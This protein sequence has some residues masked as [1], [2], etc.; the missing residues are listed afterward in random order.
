MTIIFHVDTTKRDTDDPYHSIE[1]EIRAESFACYADFWRSKHRSADHVR[2][3]LMIEP[4]ISYEMLVCYVRW[5]RHLEYDARIIEC[6]L[7]YSREG[8]VVTDWSG[9][10]RPRKYGIIGR[11]YFIELQWSKDDEAAYVFVGLNL[12]RFMTYE[13]AGQVNRY[14][15]KLSVDTLYDLFNMAL[16]D[17]V[18]MGVHYPINFNTYAPAAYKKLCE[19]KIPFSLMSLGFFDYT[20]S[21]HNWTNAVRARKMGD[22]N[23][24]MSSELD[25]E[26]FY[27]FVMSNADR[28]STYVTIDTSIKKEEIHVTTPN[29]RQRPRDRFGRFISTKVARDGVAINAT[30]FT[31]SSFLRSTDSG[32]GTA[33]D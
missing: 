24:P 28:L 31:N 32:P 4:C 27:N 30:E 10:E 13:Y 6:P 8:Y 21:H 19:V 33:I 18:S 5:L 2:L 22:T 26:H 3:R 25:V 23:A 1:E 11:R 20:I 14:R 15:S 12:M 29:T 7:V 9:K 16:G 17:Y